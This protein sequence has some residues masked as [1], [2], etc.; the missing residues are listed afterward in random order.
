MRLW[1]IGTKNVVALLGSALSPEQEALIMDAVGPVG[2]VIL[3]FGEDDAGRVCCEDV[4]TRLSVQVYVKVIGLGAEGAQPDSL[5]D[6][7][8]RKLGML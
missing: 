4:L 3:M 2:K 6:E 5:T 1:Q 7:D 8:L